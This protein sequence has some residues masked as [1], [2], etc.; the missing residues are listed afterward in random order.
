ML[1]KKSDYDMMT[2]I[3]YYIVLYNIILDTVYLVV[4]IDYGE[5]IHLCSKACA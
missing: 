4:L 3:L 1:I 5:I 2:I